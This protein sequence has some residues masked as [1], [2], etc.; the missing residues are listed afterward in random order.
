MLG[1]ISLKYCV[2]AGVDTIEH[3]IYM[4]A[5]DL[6]LM[7][8]TNTWLTVTANPNLNQQRLANRNTP[9]LT[10]RVIENQPIIRKTYEKV[11]QSGTRIG[12]AFGTD[13]QHGEFAFELETA[14]DLD[15]KPFDAL[16]VA[17]HDAA[18]LCGVEDKIGTLEA[19]KWAD[20]IVVEGDP[21][22]NIS[23][24]RKI[25]AVFKDG[26]RVDRLSSW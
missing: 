3:G 19:G 4:D 9:E 10:K 7:E 18:H 16:K 20:I 5:S 8:K 12:Y 15:L 26:E 22:T 6:E 1:G 11:F 14:V 2:E 17:T 24:I 23:D 25:K 13:A 21:L